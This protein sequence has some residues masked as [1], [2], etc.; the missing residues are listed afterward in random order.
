MRARLASVRYAAKRSAAHRVVLLPIISSP[1]SA[2]AKALTMSSSAP[3]AG[4]DLR[5]VA[6]DKPRRARLGGA[7]I[8]GLVIS[9][10]MLIIAV[11][12]GVFIKSSFAPT[13]RI[14]RTTALALPAPLPH[15]ARASR[16]FPPF[17]SPKTWSSPPLRSACSSPRSRPTLA[18]RSAATSRPRSRRSA[19]RPRRSPSPP[20]RATMA[21]TRTWTPTTP[22]SVSS[23][24]RR[25]RALSPR[26]A[27]TTQSPPRPPCAQ[28]TRPPPAHPMS[29]S[30]RA[31]RAAAA[32][33][34]AARAL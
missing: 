32:C 14:L 3:D 19:S 21:L 8:K 6:V 11:C 18:S 5:A 22:S 28:T 29:C 27:M 20:S 9:F 4:V 30:P 34:R 26:R 16:A 15:A 33:T 1:H 12:L 10:A 24:R 25:A 23:R 7:C 17:R 2:T 31:R 13:V